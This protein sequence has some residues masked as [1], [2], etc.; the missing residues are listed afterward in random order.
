ME[1][2]LLGVL[3]GETGLLEEIVLNISRGKFGV[4]TKVNTDEFTETGGVI[5][6]DGFSVTIRFKDRVAHNNLILNGHFLSIAFS[7]NVSSTDRGKVLDDF[8]RV[9]GFSCTR[10][11]GDKDR[12]VLSVLDHVT[13]GIVGDSENVRG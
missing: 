1:V 11:T 7:L 2:S 13:V 4:L 5:V 8:F 12:L 6:T 9:F 3:V 10:F